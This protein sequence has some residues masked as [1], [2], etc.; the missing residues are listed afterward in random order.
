MP[1]S[2]WKVGHGE[3]EEAIEEVKRSTH[4]L[5]QAVDEL[6]RCCDYDRYSALH[7]Q[8]ALSALEEAEQH[9]LVARRK[10]RALAGAESPITE[11]QKK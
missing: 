9:T 3:L 11:V 2:S 4:A 6:R 8:Q 7:L 1:L 10:V 5:A